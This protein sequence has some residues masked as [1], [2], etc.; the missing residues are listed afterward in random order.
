MEDVPSQNLLV[1]LIAMASKRV[2]YFLAI[3]LAISIF[4]LDLLVPRGIAVGMLYVLVVLVSL[5]T[6]GQ[7]APLAAASACS[8]LIMLG[9]YYSAPGGLPWMFLANRVLA[10]FSVWLTAGLGIQSKQTREEMQVLRLRRVR[11]ALSLKD[12]ALSRSEEELHKKSALLKSIVDS[13][14]DGVIVADETGHFL[15]F[16]PAAERLAGLGAVEGGPEKWTEKYGL[17]LPGG[18]VPYPPE[19][20]PLARAITG[21]VVEEAEVV[22]RNPEYPHN[23]TLSVNAAPVRDE[24]GRLR[25]GVALFRDITERKKIE[26]E[27]LRAKNDADLANRAK[28]IFLA[29]MSHEIRTP[30]NA[31]IGLTELMLNS[32]PKPEQREYME[33]VRESGQS[34]LEVI[35][36]ILDFSKVEVGKLSLEPITFDLREEVGDVMK[37]LAF[38]GHT[39]GLEIACR[40]APRVPDYLIGDPLRLRQV[41]VNLVGN[42]I[43]FTEKGEVV[44]S[45]EPGE[46]NGDNLWLR[47]SVRDT[48]MGI[49]KHKQALIFQAFEQGAQPA[50]RDVGGTGLGLAI[51][52]H[53]VELMGGKV[54]VESETGKGSTFSFTARLAVAPAPAPVETASRPADLS[55]VR[56][57]VVESQE[58]SRT[59]LIE[60]LESWRMRPEGM[61][62]TREAPG[63]LREATEQGDPY[64][65][66][67]LDAGPEGENALNRIERILADSPDLRIIGLCNTGEGPQRIAQFSERGVSICLIKPV[68]A[69]ELF[70]ALAET[71]GL[72]Q[73]LA[74]GKAARWPRLPRLRVLLAEDSIANQK[75]AQGLLE[76]EGHSVVIAADGRQALDA[77]GRQEFDLVLMDLQMPVMDGL[78]AT[79]AIRAQEPAGRRI[80]IIALTAHALKGDRERCLA[81]GMD[82]YVAKPIRPRRLFETISGVLLSR[83]STV[84]RETVPPASAAALDWDLALAS[85][86][87]DEA[88]LEQVA[89]AFLSEAPG[90]TEGLRRA[91]GDSNRDEARR[92]AH[93]LKG[94]L[95]HL[96]AGA[97]AQTAYELEVSA[98]EEDWGAAKRHAAELERR[99]DPVLGKLGER[100]DGKSSSGQSETEPRSAKQA[101]GPPDTE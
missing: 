29:N 81:V 27:L 51:T 90:W 24:E 43:K 84:P 73:D 16:N 52:A 37:S 93:T 58:T 78:E 77:V 64:R 3:V 6:P 100:V 74:E 31:I 70:D 97:A 85:T 76:K 12:E 63:R 11:E 9:A 47:F 68:K 79:A 10:I 98:A 13:M 28:S 65:L 18:E 46:R 99:L 5:L 60:M 50:S 14:N 48:G 32:D 22:V 49:P 59:I 21:E 67:L 86:G 41:I 88:L 89:S 66:L 44:L 30:L 2:A 75:L 34:L 72:G 15:V 45:V 101:S 92:L 36:D 80:P 55:G 42:A 96:G 83:R 17:F 25:G 54:W 33:L 4:A 1:C 23:V 61:A 7:L 71:L 57:L 82:D 39:K 19:K 87:G 53:L 56:V 35:N 8:G 69:S 26:A 62:Q 38:R 20:L 40:I 95:N 91:V 94:A